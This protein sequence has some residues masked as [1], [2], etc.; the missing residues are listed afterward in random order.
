M[1][2]TLALA[3]VSLIPVHGVVL[4]TLRDGSAIVRTEPVTQMLPERIRRYVLRPS[5][6]FEP[7]TN[8][9]AFLDAARPPALLY[10]V[11]AAPFAPGLPDSGKAAPV[12][13]GGTLPPALLVD[14]SARPVQLD[15]AFREQDVAAV[16]RL[17]ALPRP[18]ALPGDQRE[19]RIPSAPPRSRAFR[20]R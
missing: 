4:D 18:D 3:A 11:A 5:A 8:L 9:D 12:V 17:H 15:R 16:V 2:A 19:V 1:I 10:P 13:L 7:G 6:A 20:A 14:Q